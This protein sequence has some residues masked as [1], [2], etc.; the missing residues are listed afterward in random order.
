MHLRRFVQLASP[1]KT[2]ELGSIHLHVFEP[3]LCNLFLLPLSSLKSLLWMSRVFMLP[4][5]V[6]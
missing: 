5:I 2:I 4:S 6:D 1:R 3:L